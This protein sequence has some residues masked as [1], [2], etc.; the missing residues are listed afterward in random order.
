LSEGLERAGR[1]RYD[2]IVADLG[3]PD[4]RGLETVLRLREHCAGVPIVIVTGLD[5][6]EVA[7]AA[8]RAGAQDYVPKAGLR[9]YPLGRAVVHAVERGRAAEALRQSQEH[10]R[11][12]FESLPTPSFLFDEET[13]E[14]LAVNE[15]V[16][17]LYGWSREELL[18]MTLRD[19]RPPDEVADLLHNVGQ[20][21][22][23]EE[24]VFMG[25]RRHWAKDGREI[26][27][28]VTTRPFPF[29]LDG[30]RARVAMVIDATGRRRAETAETER[31]VLRDAVEAMDRVLGVVGH[32]LRTPLAGLRAISELVLAK[33]VRAGAETRNLLQSLHDE[34]VRMSDTVDALLEAA[35]LNSGRARWDWSRF[36]VGRVCL[37]AIEGMRPLV[38]G[39]RV[40]LQV[41]V[42]PSTEMWGDACAVR[43]LLT[44]LLSNA[45]RHTARGFVRVSV[46]A[47]PDGNGRAWV[48]LCVA[49]TGSG[50]PP[51]VQARLGEAFALNSGVVGASHVGGTGLGLAIC[52][53]IAEAHGGVLSVRSE[54]GR[55]STVMARLRSDLP[56]PSEVMPKAFVGRGHAA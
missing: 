42:D 48:R 28:D 52:K 45:R 11:L 24:T 4:S 21:R 29:H 56:G 55:G 27:A 35:R 53:G 8:V 19:I 40:Q 9:A 5:D 13:L 39:R 54:P 14:I 15:A 22:G 44:N 10:Y 33:E 3:L 12:L 18:G 32:E 6:D 7:A 23:R 37:E 47:E 30:R 49:D 1:G 2:A 16:A 26:Y 38:D 25:M 50:I 17:R 36:A 20:W 34:V 51:E 46:Q 31:A 43:R 41:D